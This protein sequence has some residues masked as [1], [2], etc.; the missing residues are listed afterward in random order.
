MNYSEISKNPE[1]VSYLGERFVDIEYDREIGVSLARTNLEK[2]FVPEENWNKI[3]YIMERC[4]IS[5]LG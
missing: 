2:I 1:V 3:E 4:P 5:M